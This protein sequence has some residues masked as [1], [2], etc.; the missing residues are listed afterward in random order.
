MTNTEKT[1]KQLEAIAEAEIKIQER[2]DLLDRTKRAVGKLDRD[3]RKEARAEIDL[4]K[5]ELNQE[6][7]NFTKRVRNGKRLI[8]GLVVFKDGRE[9][10]ELTKICRAILSER[11]IKGQKWECIA[12]TTGYS[13]R[14]IYRL[15]GLALSSIGKKV[16]KAPS[17]FEK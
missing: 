9:N 7:I 14:Y 15:H 13:L 8:D 5:T 4:L 12:V 2:K 17:K 6:V 10:K 16:K 11:Y 3:L 1:K